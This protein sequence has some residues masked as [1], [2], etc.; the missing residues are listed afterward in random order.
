M[1]GTAFFKR[2]VMVFCLQKTMESFDPFFQRYCIIT[3]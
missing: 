1:M 3:H 2:V